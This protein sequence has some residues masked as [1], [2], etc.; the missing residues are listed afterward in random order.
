M[1]NFFLYNISKIQ[2]KKRGEYSWDIFVWMSANYGAHLLH[3]SIWRRNGSLLL[4][5][6]L[7]NEWIDKKNYIADFKSEPKGA[8]KS[9]SWEMFLP[10]TFF[11][12]KLEKNC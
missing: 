7:K 9:V 10:V 12:G 8:Q 11:P 5:C 4:H 3:R 2:V 6:I 1:Q